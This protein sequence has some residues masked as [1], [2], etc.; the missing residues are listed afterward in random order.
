MKLLAIDSSGL[1]A[2]AAVLQDEELIA[3]YTVNFKKT[4]SQ[5]LLPMIAQVR[6]LLQ[7]D[8][9]TIDAVAIAA[10]PGSFTGLRI[11]ASTA[12]GLGLALQKPLIAVPTVDALAYNLVGCAGRVCPLMNA[13]RNRAYTGIYSFSGTRMNV[14][15]EQC[16][17]PLDE[18]TG[19]INQSPEPVMFLGDGVTEFAEQIAMLCTVPY[20]FAPPH[21]S[22]QRAGAVA[23][24]AA[25]YYRRGEMVSADDFAPVYLRLPQA[26]RERLEREEKEKTAATAPET[27][28][29]SC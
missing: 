2:S 10:G 8:L 22:R 13:R 11:G 12:K 28:G 1:V 15:R 23:A 25:E 21:L 24:L 14:L 18:I 29:P 6:D 19:E 16:C 26:E 3:E 17:V 7:L 4:H 20:T 27:K 5:T 9:K